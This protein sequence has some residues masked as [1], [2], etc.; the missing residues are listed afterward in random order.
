[1]KNNYLF[2]GI[3][4]FVLCCFLTNVQAQ[5]T[6]SKKSCSKAKT[7]KS[8]ETSE[9]SWAVD[10][11]KSSCSKRRACNKRRNYSN[12]RPNLLFVGGGGAMDS[13]K[14]VSA[15]TA[16]EYERKL[17]RNFGVGALAEATFS[18]DIA[19]KFGLPVSYHLNRN[20]RLMASPLMSLQETM[21]IDKLGV[22]EK[23]MNSEFGA[24][25]A[26]SYFVKMHGLIIAP[27]IRGDYLDG[28]ITPGFGV[29]V[30][31]RF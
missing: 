22:E 14:N 2:S 4:T 5:C 26:L 6:K 27:T 24:R 12:Y 7:E 1:M 16:L 19:Y 25:V 23:S 13:E 3:L 31:A 20:I 9:T 30:G 17:T 11:Y 15:T 18:D 28:D 29:N 21:G 8:N 10:S